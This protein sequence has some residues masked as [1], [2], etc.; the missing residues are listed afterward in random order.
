M[1]R[2]LLI[3]AVAAIA[4]GC[5][6]TSKMAKP[7]TD[8]TA[9]TTEAMRVTTAA[10]TTVQAVDQDSQ[11]IE[12]SLAEKTPQSLREQD[13]KQ[14]LRPDDLLQRQLALQALS[15]YAATL[16]ALSTVDKSAD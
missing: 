2:S 14:I 6:S 5:A 16:K 11:A 12:R 10:L 7:L 8:F 9:A 1:N 3:C 4:S 15:T 13:V